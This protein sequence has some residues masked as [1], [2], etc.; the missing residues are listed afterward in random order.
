MISTRFRNLLKSNVVILLNIL[1]SGRI[2]HSA[3]S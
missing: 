2:K 1:S 3:H